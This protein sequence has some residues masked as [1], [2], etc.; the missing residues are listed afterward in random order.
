MLS[1]VLIEFWTLTIFF[2]RKFVKIS[3]KSTTIDTYVGV[4]TD[5]YKEV[6]DGDWHL[7]NGIW[8]DNSFKHLYT[9]KFFH[10]K[11][12]QIAIEYSI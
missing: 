12:R 2:D 7:C 1:T 6:V 4:Y 8:E 9:A 11:S 10:L 3:N 5:E